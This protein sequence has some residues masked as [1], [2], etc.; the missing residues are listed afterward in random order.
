M[1]RFY[2]QAQLDLCNNP[3]HNWP[4]WLNEGRKAI[5]IAGRRAMIDLAFQAKSAW[6]EL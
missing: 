4:G 1:S 2:V 3:L 5:A 6:F